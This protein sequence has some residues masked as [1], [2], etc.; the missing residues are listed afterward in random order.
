MTQERFMARQGDVLLITAAA[1]PAEARKVRGRMVLAEGEATGHAHVLEAPAAGEAELL[2]MGDRLFARI[3]DG[4]ARVVH[5]EHAAVILPP[6]DYEIIRQ[7]EYVPPPA[8]MPGRAATR[9]VRD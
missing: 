2:A 6:G 4:D 3:L 9:R 1:I 8:G 7:R 5:E